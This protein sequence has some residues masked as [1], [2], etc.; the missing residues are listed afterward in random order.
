MSDS[1]PAL[2][3]PAA[4]P[5]QHRVADA[6]V[7]L[8]TLPQLAAQPPEAH[9]PTV[10]ESEYDSETTV[11]GGLDS[12][13]EGGEGD[14]A[15]GRS[16]AA[17]DDPDDDGSESPSAPT[18]A[19]S[20][21]RREGGQSSSEIARHASAARWEKHRTREAASPGGEAAQAKREPKPWPDV[22]FES[23]SRLSVR[24][25]ALDAAPA[26]R[27]S[28][29][30]AGLYEPCGLIAELRAKTT[31]VTH[32][33]KGRVDINAAQHAPG[34]AG[35]FSD[36]E[37]VS[38]DDGPPYSIDVMAERFAADLLAFL[39]DPSAP[40]L[41]WAAV[42]LLS[43]HDKVKA[44]L[45]FAAERK[46]AAAP[47]AS[48]ATAV[49]REAASPL[50]PF[51]KAEPQDALRTRSGLFSPPVQVRCPGQPCMALLRTPSLAPRLGTQAAAPA[52]APKAP[53]KAARASGSSAAAPGPAL[54]C[55]SDI[56]REIN[57]LEARKAALL[58]AR[59]ESAARVRHAC[60]AS[61]QVVVSTRLPSQ[62]MLAGTAG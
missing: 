23:R 40:Q 56:D 43:H 35:A 19:G 46:R 15:P 26:H 4:R 61:W 29:V 3:S 52:R 49:A 20:K 7:A 32:M 30:I 50:A 27:I 37:A 10:N 9:A 2:E 60:G 28:A 14:P 18:A 41:S 57:E 39:E 21:R 16:P 36:S 11:P 34:S 55:V 22:A 17:A 44:A 59:E 45:K 53:P 12:E 48:A 13:G 51:V 1:I 8:A 38:N 31:L 54:P 5:R 24:L 42:K 58:R 62:R 25:S 47:V 33:S 6:D